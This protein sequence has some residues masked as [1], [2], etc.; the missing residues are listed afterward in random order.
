MANKKFSLID[1]L[2]ANCPNDICDSSDGQYTY[3]RIELHCAWYCAIMLKGEILHEKLSH[4]M[5]SLN[6]TW[7]NIK[8]EFNSL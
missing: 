5:K 6:E 7:L 3:H 4:D 8:H 2:E 1:I